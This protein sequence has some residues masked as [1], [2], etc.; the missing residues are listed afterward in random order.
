MARLV[1]VSALLVIALLGSACRAM[2][3][4]EA[5]ETIRQHLAAEKGSIG[6]ADICS[7]YPCCYMDSGDNCALQDMPKLPSTVVFP[8]GQTRCIFSDSTDYAFQVWP[9]ATDKLLFYFQ[10]GGACWDQSSTSPA[11]LCYTDISAQETHGVFDREDPTNKF[12]EYT[13]VHLM[14]CSGDMFV[15]NVV[16]PYNDSNGVP[17]TQ[18]VGVFSWL[19]SYHIRVVFR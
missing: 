2:T 9:G 5:R 7:K 11:P 15:G 14:Y 3:E 10:G 6:G 18:R 17:V 1:I 16:R 13:I 8:G 4:G 19:I 12:S